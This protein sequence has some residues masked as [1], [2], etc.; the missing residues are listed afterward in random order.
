MIIIVTMA[1][2]RTAYLLTGDVN[3]ERCQFSKNVLEKVGFNVI[4]FNFFP[5]ENKVISNKNS[6]VAIYELIANGDDEWVYVFEDDI[7]VLEDVKLDEIIK[8]ES[9]STHFFY[10]GLCVCHDN[11]KIYTNCNKINDNEVIIVKGKIRGLHAIALHKNGAKELIE[12]IKKNDEHVYMDVILEE[13]S[14]LHPANVVRFDLQSYMH[15]HRGVFFQDRRK[16]P[17]TII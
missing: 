11:N 4:C 15:G 17:S 12:F 14:V 10:L 9:I 5:H 3:S 1:I 16:F 8:Y 6:M 7:N 2:S 13:F